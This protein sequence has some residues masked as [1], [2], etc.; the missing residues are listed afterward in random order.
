LIP[1][2]ETRNYVQRVMENV[3]M[4]RAVRNDPAPILPTTPWTR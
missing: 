4:Y 3:V 1:V 2:G